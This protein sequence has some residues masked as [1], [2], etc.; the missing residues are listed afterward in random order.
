MSAEGEE[1]ELTVTKGCP[2]LDAGQALKLIQ[3]L[4]ETHLRE[5]QTGTTFTE[6]VV[7]VARISWWAAL[8]HYV[9]SG[10]ASM[11]RLVL[12][13]APFSSGV[14]EEGKATW[15]KEDVH[16][17]LYECM[18]RLPVNRRRRKRL[19]RSA[20]W[21]VRW[22]PEGVDRQQ[23]N[24]M[25]LDGRFDAVELNVKNLVSCGG[26]LQ[27]DVWHVLILGAKLGK[28]SALVARERLPGEGPPSSWS[29]CPW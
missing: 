4:E 2:E 20:A 23:D 11:A 22:D 25:D 8:Q 18:K 15:L 3:R 13:R 7:R 27:Q 6:R 9:T 28:I 17:S 12:E 1:L 5:I 21:L 14:L 24:L 10:Q 19:Q 26:N 16:E 29:E